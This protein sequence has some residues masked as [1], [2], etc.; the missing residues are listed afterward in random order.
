VTV[1]GIPEWSEA[2]GGQRVLLGA[3]FVVGSLF[4]VNKKAFLYTLVVG[5]VFGLA[6]ALP[7]VLALDACLEEE[8]PQGEERRAAIGNLSAYEWHEM[9]CGAIETCAERI[10]GF[11]I[12]LAV[13]PILEE[14]KEDLRRG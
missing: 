5:G 8:M 7:P 9:R 12:E 2:S 11:Q 1:L 4:S 13:K 6:F 10:G 3:I 14:C